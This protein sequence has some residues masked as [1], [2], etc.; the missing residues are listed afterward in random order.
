L[1]YCGQNTADRSAQLLRIAQPWVKLPEPGVGGLVA[2]ICARKHGLLNLWRDEKGHFS[3]GVGAA[4]ETGQ[5]RGAPGRGVR[6]YGG[7]QQPKQSPDN[8]REEVSPGLMEDTTSCQPDL[9]RLHPGLLQSLQTI[10]QGE[11]H[12]FEGRAQEVR[13]SMGEVESYPGATG[14]RVEMRRVLAAQVG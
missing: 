13:A 12:P 6:H 2:L 10:A 8:L 4:S 1:N 3:R 14:V 11:G 9:R 5:K 7:M